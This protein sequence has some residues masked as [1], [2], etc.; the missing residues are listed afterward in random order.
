MSHLSWNSHQNENC[1]VLSH[2]TFDVLFCY[3]HICLVLQQ[4]R[5]YRSQLRS[6][7]DRKWWQQKSLFVHSR[8]RREFFDESFKRFKSLHTIDLFF[9]WLIIVN[10][11]SSAHLHFI[12][13]TKFYLICRFSSSRLMQFWRF[14]YLLKSAW[15]EQRL[16]E[17]ILIYIVVFLLSSFSMLIL[18]SLC[19]FSLVFVI[20]SQVIH[21]NL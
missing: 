13:I 14:W 6:F 12:V 11:T 1:S 4:Q 2:L 7:V 8:W 17:S 21:I 20:F 16:R 5:E 10:W 3:N 19:A 18:V 9:D 15:A